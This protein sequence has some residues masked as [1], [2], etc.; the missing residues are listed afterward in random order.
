MYQ[1][2][3]EKE[4][5]DILKPLGLAVEV[6]TEGE[7]GFYEDEHG[8]QRVPHYTPFMEQR[9]NTE[10]LREI[11]SGLLRQIQNANSGATAI[12]VRD[13]TLQQSPNIGYA[14][15]IRCALVRRKQDLEGATR[16]EDYTISGEQVKF[17][18]ALEALKNG[19]RVR[20]ESWA[21]DTF[22]YLVPGSQFVVNRA[23]LLGIYPEGTEIVYA[24]HIDIKAGA[25]HCQVWQVS[26]DAVL[27]E[28]WIICMRGA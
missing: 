6:H 5:K 9:A 25:N 22:I 27:A 14:L 10:D 11:S 12:I 4:I 19:F 2:L 18:I 26:Q 24:P 8:E 3:T 28:D 21:P 23:P 13:M 7:V 20:R 1:T 16:F 17:G 15:T